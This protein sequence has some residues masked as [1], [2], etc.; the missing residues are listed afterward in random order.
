MSTAPDW[1]NLC[2]EHN[3]PAPCG[4]CALTS[5]DITTAADAGAEA[6]RLDA[7]AAPLE[8]GS[9]PRRALLAAATQMWNLRDELGGE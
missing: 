7:L 8:R 5:C 6:R 3:C 4:L 2:P 1:S 9:A